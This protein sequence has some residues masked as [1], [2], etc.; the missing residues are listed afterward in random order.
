MVALLPEASKQQLADA[1]LTYPEV[2]ATANEHMPAQYLHLDRSHKL[3][4]INFDAAAEQLLAWRVHE[5]SGL[6]VAA[7]H[8][9]VEPDAV[10][11]MRLGRGRA[12]LRIPCRVVYVISEIDSVGFAYG[13]LPGHPESGEERFTIERDLAGG[14]SMRIR[15]FSKPATLLAQASGPI[16][17]AM[18]SIMTE[19]YLTAFSTQ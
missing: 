6:K 15:A 5:Q 8:L 18:Q 4:G 9:T 7:S 3:L 11:L 2:G 12:S 14:V 16:G 10:V 1:T 17:R 13:T 19:R